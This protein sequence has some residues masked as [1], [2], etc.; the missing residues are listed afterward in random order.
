MGLKFDMS[1]L[2]AGLQKTQNRAVLAV[3]AYGET[4][5]IKLQNHA[6]SKAPW[7]D[8]TG[9]ARRQLRGY[10]KDQTYR[11]VVRVCLAHGVDYGIWL[12]LANEMRYAIVHPTI[13][14]KAQEV[15]QGLERLL[16][17]M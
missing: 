3:L 17:R 8:R 12:E 11:S 4:S 16:E 14:L 9:M 1:G 7:T 5:A 2:E 10:V 13:Q 6:Q 15:F